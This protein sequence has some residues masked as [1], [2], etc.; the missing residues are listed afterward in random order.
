MLDC[1][2]ISYLKVLLKLRKSRL[3]NWEETTLLEI[4]QKKD[5][6]NVLMWRHWANPFEGQNM[7]MIPTLERITQMM[8]FIR[9]SKEKS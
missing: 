7:I 5:W 6:L 8:I 4:L 3:N 9:L 2:L 1:L